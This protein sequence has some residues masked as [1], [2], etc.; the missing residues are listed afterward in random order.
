MRERIK[1]ER[2]GSAYWALSVEQELLTRWP[3]NRRGS[4][5]HFSRASTISSLPLLTGTAHAAHARRTRT[6]DN[7]SIVA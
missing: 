5:P 7:F 3:N 6:R 4:A 1:M 2:E